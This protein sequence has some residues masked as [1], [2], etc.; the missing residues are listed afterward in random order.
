MTFGLMVAYGT[1]KMVPQML[2]ILDLEKNYSMNQMATIVY[3]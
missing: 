2:I 3:L 1:G